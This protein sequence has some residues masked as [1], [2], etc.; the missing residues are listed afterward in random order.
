MARMIIRHV[1][2]YC[3]DYCFLLLLGPAHLAQD[4]DEDI[5]DIF[6]IYLGYRYNIFGIFWIY[7][8]YNWNICDL[9]NIWDI[10][11][12]CAI[13]LEFFGYIWNILDI[14]GIYLEYIWNEWLGHMK[15]H[16]H[17]VWDTHGICNDFDF[18]IFQ[19]CRWTHVEIG[20]LIMLY[21]C[22]W[23]A[24]WHMSRRLARELLGECQ[25]GG[26]RERGQLAQELQ[27][28]PRRQAGHV[29]RWRK[30]VCGSDREWEP[31][32]AS[33]V[34]SFF[35]CSSSQP[36]ALATRLRVSQGLQLA[37]G[38]IVRSLCPKVSASRGLVAQQSV[39]SPDP[40]L[41]LPM[42][43][44][45]QSAHLSPFCTRTS[46]PPPCSH[47]LWDEWVRKSLPFP[48]KQLLLKVFSER[49]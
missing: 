33:R 35:Q 21:T 22:M 44:I 3:R 1:W 41:G 16:I 24:W 32:K 15:Y 28:L 2:H 19:L 26:S 34:R 30:D 31:N 10:W 7:F 12:I 6:A 36:S 20:S 39:I 8:Q 4:C 14:F 37:V 40:C 43:K 48:S 29:P 47:G 27:R 5:W 38:V 46:V 23:A 13:Y 18:K 49:G 42:Q 17:G 9:C 45:H 25:E 11:D